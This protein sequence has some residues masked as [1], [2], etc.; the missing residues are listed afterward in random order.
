MPDAARGLE[1]ALCLPLFTLNAGHV[2]N[3]VPE[4]L[5]EAGFKGPV[6]NH[7]GAHADVP[8]MIAAALERHS[9]A[10]MT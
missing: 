10:A 1:A 9:A 8:S 7:I 6:L 5:A 2:L 3:D 4:A